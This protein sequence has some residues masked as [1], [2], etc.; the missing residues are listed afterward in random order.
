[1]SGTI[2]DIGA[3]SGPSNSLS[4]AGIL[5]GDWHTIGGGETGHTMPDP[6]DPNIVYAGE[7]GGFISRYDHR[8]RQ[9]RNISIYPTN[10]SGHGAESLRFRFQWTAPIL[11]SPHD[12]KT[13]YHAA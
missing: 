9:A 2:Q 4:S 10:P 1:V 13:V 5:P 12:P 6:S 8:T 11:V 3:A 7:Y